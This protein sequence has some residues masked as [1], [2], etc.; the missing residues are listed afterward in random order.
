MAYSKAAAL[1][2]ASYLKFSRAFKAIDL[3]PVVSPFAFRHV[4]TFSRG[5]PFVS[6]SEGG[7]FMK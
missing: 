3:T 6:E 5:E 4:D 1:Y 7:E 2:F